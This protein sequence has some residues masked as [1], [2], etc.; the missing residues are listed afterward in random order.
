M[1]PRPAPTAL[2]VLA[3]LI[4]A[5]GSG[6]A[7]TLC[8]SGVP[9]GA[10]QQCESM[11]SDHQKYLQSLADLNNALKTDPKAGDPKTVAAISAFYKMKA[12]SIDSFNTY[13]ALVPADK[14]LEIITFNP[15]QMGIAKMIE[16][17]MDA[18]VPQEVRDLAR[19]GG[20]ATSGK[21]AET[22]AKT[23]GN[24]ETKPALT[25]AQTALN[26][27]DFAGA[28]KTLDAAIAKNPN[29]AAAH[30]LRAQALVGQGKGEEAAA[31][32]RKALALDP[33]DKFAR[34]IV[35]E[36]A[37]LAHA[38][39]ITNKFKK[40]SDGLLHDP[41]DDGGAGGG[42]AQAMKALS[43]FGATGP[44][45]SRTGQPQVAARDTPSTSVSGAAGGGGAP[46]AFA[47][48]LQTAL[49]KQ[50]VGDYTGALIDVSQEIDSNPND[51]AAWVLR[52]ELDLQLSNYPA[53]I[54]DA[55]RALGLNPDD[56]RALRARAYGEYETK[57]YKQALA[58]ATRAV[59]LDPK[60]G[61]GFLYKAMAEEKLGLDDAA[62]A[63][64]N[65][66][67]ALDPTLKRLAAPLLKK[68]NLGG[69]PADSSA[70]RLKP[71]MLRGG[72]VGVAMLLILIGLLGTQK[73][74][75]LKA[76]LLTPRRAQTDAPAYAGELA[77]GSVLGG[78]YRIV[79]EIGRGGMGVVYE[80]M[81]ES[82]QRRVAVKRLLQDDQTTPEDTERF[83]REARLVAQLKHPNLA[84]IY[85]V[86]VEREPFLVF[87]YVDGETLDGVLS[88][89]VVLAPAAARRI[90]GEIANALSCAHA[91]NIIH[92]DL[93]PSNV[94]IAKSGAAKVMDFGIAHKSR[95]AAT[96]LTQT[97]A[98]GTPPYMAPE[99]GMGSVS[100]ASDLYALGVMTYELLTGR[101]PF[102]GPNYLNQKLE[103]RYEP[104]TR[105]NPELPAALDRF[106]ESALDPD[107]TKRPESASAFMEALGRACDATPRQASAA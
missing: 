12:Q 9:S 16:Q 34:Q 76:I 55:T 77:P 98:C 4:F 74:K 41:A 43:G 18:T 58:D 57:L 87:E 71:W 24:A 35:D 8:S 45:G 94:M 23:T 32:A 96:Q 69:G 56:P 13:L 10:Q 79:R 64:L 46:R 70:F 25:T 20:A 80:G 86:A 102:Q 50:E 68:Y 82:L 105:L 2:L 73:T 19:N 101:R 48:L 6:R 52:A 5:S 89:S 15:S 107:P 103:R 30:S 99:Q 26:G 90:V 54:A 28:V 14:Q 67:L 3:S 31:E 88:R 53:G 59:Q 29:D 44:A 39:G 27:G 93:K 37:H 97:I 83:L 100:K 40:L 22:E 92:R 42:G 104:A 61:L 106:F 38:D 47:P 85:A 63:D 84:Q 51:P 36:Q 7:E 1:R 78:G 66:A 81:D 60:N 95:T 21:A 91:H 72:F 33:S 49:R 62:V 65:Q 75:T 17:R 11:D